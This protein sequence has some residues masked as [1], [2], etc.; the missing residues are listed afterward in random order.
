MDQQFLN[1]IV[2][3]SG[4][5]LVGLGGMWISVQQL[6]KRMDDLMARISAVEMRIETLESRMEGRFTRADLSLKEYY[7]L[8][9]QNAADL[10]EAAR[11]LAEQEK[12]IERIE[13]RE[14]TYGGG[15]GAGG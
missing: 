9:V 11:L 1:T 8:L 13:E 4:A 12:R 2:S 15:G 3:T 14:R 6:G 7:G 10:K 5:V